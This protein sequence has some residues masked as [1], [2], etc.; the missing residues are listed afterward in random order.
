M[1]RIVQR[2]VA[3]RIPRRRGVRQPPRS[4]D[5]H[6]RLAPR[7][8]RLPSPL[9]ARHAHP[10]RVRS[11]TT[12]T[13]SLIGPGPTNGG[14]PSKL[15]PNEEAHDGP[16]Q[17]CPLRTRPSTDRGR[18][19]ARVVD[20]LDPRRGGLDLGEADRPDR[21]GAWGAV[22]GPHG[23]TQRSPSQAAVGSSRGH[24]GRGP[25]LRKGSSF[26]ELL[27]PRRRIGRAL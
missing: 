20:W 2:E 21:C 9:R 27:E 14:N 11:T 24:R 5:R 8:Q 3:R 22:P 26:C 7:L 4:P 1:D 15:R 12:T 23:P 19:H 17:F 25:E 16:A 10:D 18:W 13:D 6:R